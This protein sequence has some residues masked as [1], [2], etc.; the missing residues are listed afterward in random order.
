MEGYIA[1][2]LLFAGDFAPRHWAYCQGQTLSINANTALFSLLGTTYGG[3]G[4]TNFALP[5]FAGRTAVGAGAGAGLSQVAIGEMGGSEATTLTTSMMPAHTHTLNATANPGTAVSL[6]GNVFAN[7]GTDN[8]YL[9][10][11][12]PVAME[13]ESIGVTGSNQPFDSRQPYSGINYVICLFGIFPQ[14]S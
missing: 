14:R 12:T 10:A 5:N 9:K 1:Q 2:I 4:Q 6:A 13:N 8:F 11:G 3:N 7:S